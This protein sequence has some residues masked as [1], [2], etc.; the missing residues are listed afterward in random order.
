MRAQL[1]RSWWWVSMWMAGGMTLA[2]TGPD[3][4]RETARFRLRGESAHALWLIEEGLRRSPTL[5]WLVGELATTDVIVHVVAAPLEDLAGR[6]VFQVRAGGHRYLAMTISTRQ[7]TA[8]QL[9]TLAHELVHV[10]E[11][12]DD[13]GVASQAGM[14]RLYERIGERTQRAGRYETAAARKVGQR[15]LG[16]VT[17]P[18][19]TPVDTVALMR[20]TRRGGTGGGADP[21]L[22]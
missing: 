20:L 18:R 12:A 11:V 4:D 21:V 15:A 6:T 1:G 16:E 19:R 2:A 13:A 7:P 9:A 17:N 5:R 14:R 8:V 10:L 3:I 22:R